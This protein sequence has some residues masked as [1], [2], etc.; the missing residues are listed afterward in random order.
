MANCF[1]ASSGKE[2][3]VKEQSRARGEAELHGA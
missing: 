2:H 1:G 3:F